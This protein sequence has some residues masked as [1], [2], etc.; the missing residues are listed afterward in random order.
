M[1]KW[2]IKIETD[3]TECPFLE[4]KECQHELNPTFTCSEENC[5][6]KITLEE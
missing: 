6:F 2:K 1:S 4:W 3:N 5:P